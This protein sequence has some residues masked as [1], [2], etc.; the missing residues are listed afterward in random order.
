MRNKLE[1]GGTSIYPTPS[2]LDVKSFGSEFGQF[3]MSFGLPHCDGCI[4]VISFVPISAINN[5]KLKME[6]EEDKGLTSLPVGSF[7]D[8][9]TSIWGNLFKT[10]TSFCK[11]SQN[12][13]IYADTSLFYNEIVDSCHH[14]VILKELEY[15]D[16]LKLKSGPHAI[17]QSDMND[18]Q[19][20]LKSVIYAHAIYPFHNNDS[21][22]DYKTYRFPYK[23][24]ITYDLVGQISSS[25]DAIR[26]RD[27]LISMTNDARLHVVT[28]LNLLADYAWDGKCSFL[29]SNIPNANIDL[30]LEEESDGVKSITFASNA[31]SQKGDI[32]GDIRFSCPVQT[33]PTLSKCTTNNANFQIHVAT[34]GLSEVVQSTKFEPFGRVYIGTNSNPFQYDLNSKPISSGDER[35]G[36]AIETN[37]LPS[38]F[39]V[40]FEN[41]MIC[42]KDCNVKTNVQSVQLVSNGIQ[43]VSQNYLSATVHDAIF[44]NSKN[45]KE[46]IGFS[47]DISSTLSM[48]I[49]TWSFVAE[50]KFTPK[51][52]KR[53]DVDERNELASEVE[54]ATITKRI[55]LFPSA[56][57]GATT[58]VE[59]NSADK[60]VAILIPSIAGGICL[61]CMF[62]IVALVGLILLGS[63]LRKGVNGKGHHKMEEDASVPSDSDVDLRNHAV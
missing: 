51:G 56:M 35:V 18:S 46:S 25:I 9:N 26:Q 50:V 57:S 44:M 2:Q 53:T 49:S 39:G 43:Q 41:V 12:Q 38:D 59:S 31:L 32:E 61:M 58:S 55:D 14:S 37:N 33:C 40:S 3:G 30:I 28:K 8:P 52:L 15:G 62:G 45:M 48:K 4:W 7:P 5:R 29:S 6:Y 17:F 16:M 54:T 11:D 13:Y 19:L 47:F 36:I 20:K 27:L 1:V 23:I 10:G 22:D 42:P 60:L 34:G 21:S 24:S 63:I